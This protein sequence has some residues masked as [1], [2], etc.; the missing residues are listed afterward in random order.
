MKIKPLSWD[1]GFQFVEKGYFYKNRVNSLSLT[2]NPFPVVK[3]CVCFVGSAS[4]RA[5]GHTRP[6]SMPG[7]SVGL[8]PHQA[9]TLAV[10]RTQLL[11]DAATPTTD[12]PHWGWAPT[13]QFLITIEVYRQSENRCRGTAVLF[14]LIF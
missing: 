1:S 6:A 11:H 14:M 12:N 13:P 4:C 10:S 8:P 7:L 5:I 2:P 3:G 9:R